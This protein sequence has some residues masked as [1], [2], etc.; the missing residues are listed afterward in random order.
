M[1]DQLDAA[2]TTALQSADRLEQALERIA[3]HT[4]DGGI[5][6]GGGVEGEL[7]V[8]KAEIRQRL[9]LLISHLRATLGEPDELDPG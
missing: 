3:A 7:S 8:G 2:A 6:G 9:D 5:Q 4:Q 1:S